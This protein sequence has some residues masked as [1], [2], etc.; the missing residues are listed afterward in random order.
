MEK[1]SPRVVKLEQRGLRG[2]IFSVNSQIDKG[3]SLRKISKS[4]QS[5]FGVSI[6]HESI[7]Q[8]KFFRVK[9]KGVA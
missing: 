9:D 6:S 1:N 8:Y 3:L 2:I 7:R 4:V 5:E